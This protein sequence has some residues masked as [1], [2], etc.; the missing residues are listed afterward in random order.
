ME[1]RLKEARDE[2]EADITAAEEA[3]KRGE[4]FE[5]LLDSALW[6]LKAVRRMQNVSALFVSEARG[7]PQTAK[8][9]GKRQ[10]E[11]TEVPGKNAHKEERPKKQP[12]RKN[13]AYE[14]LKE[15]GRKETKTQSGKKT[16][17]DAARDTYPKNN[18]HQSQEQHLF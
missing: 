9:D 17:A 6:A 5:H 15:K 10:S 8:P 11:W 3:S 16:Y 13:N 7:K 2:V 18:L 12:E 14:A 4:A 1:A